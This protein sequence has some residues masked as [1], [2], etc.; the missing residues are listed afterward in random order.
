MFATLPQTDAQQLRNQ[1]NILAG[2]V[3]YEVSQI[4]AATGDAGWR[5]WLDKAIGRFREASC[6]VRGRGGAG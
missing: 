6:E 3:L 1:S 4:K 5:T 2:N